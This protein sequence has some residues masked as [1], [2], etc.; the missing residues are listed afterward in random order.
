MKTPTEGNYR[1]FGWRYQTEDNCVRGREDRQRI[2]AFVMD[3]RTAQR[4][5]EN[6]LVHWQ[7]RTA[8]GGA[9][10]VCSENLR[11]DP[12][13]IGEGSYIPDTMS[14]WRRNWRIVTTRFSSA[15]FV[16]TA[17]I[18]GA[19]RLGLHAGKFTPVH[20]CPRWYGRYTLWMWVRKELHKSAEIKDDLLLELQV[21]SRDLWDGEDLAVERTS[22]R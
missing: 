15:K 3:E 1:H 16:V 18:I 8:W 19:G 11:S 6:G 7:R 9:W 22:E 2:T 20:N 4:I 21:W 13:L 10:C 17:V 5:T 14:T 12:L